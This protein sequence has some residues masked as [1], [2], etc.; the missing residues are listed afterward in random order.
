VEQ[1]GLRIAVRNDAEFLYVALADGRSETKERRSPRG[2][3][4]WFDNE[5]GTTKRVGIRYPLLALPD[6]LRDGLERREH[7]AP[8]DRDAL[9][10]EMLAEFEWLGP[11]DGDIE[12]VPKLNTNDVVLEFRPAPE[13]F[14]YELKVPLR[15]S[16]RRPYAIG[17][18]PGS[19]IGVALEVGGMAAAGRSP[20]GGDVRGSGRPSGRPGRGERPPGGPAPGSEPGSAPRMKSEISWFRVDLAKQ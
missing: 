1:N 17:A 2:L 7:N 9:F 11:K 3:T 13:G 4:V 8:M 5:G 18:E 16:G 19:R 15:T 12:R 20:A 10:S 6:A 14:G